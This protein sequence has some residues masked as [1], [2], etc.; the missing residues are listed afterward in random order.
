MPLSDVKGQTCRRRPRG[1]LVEKTD[2]LLGVMAPPAETMDGQPAQTRRLVPLGSAAAWW[3]ISFF[4]MAGGAGLA[5]IL[6]KISVLTQ[7]VPT[8]GPPL[9]E[10]LL[11]LR[12]R[13]MRRFHLEE[14]AGGVPAVVRLREQILLASQTRLPA[15]IVGPP[16]SGKQ[17]VAR[18]IHYAGP[19]REQT[20][21]CLDCARLAPDRI[22]ELLFASSPGTRLASVYL[23]NLADLPLSLQVRLQQKLEVPR[24]R[25]SPLSR[26]F[27]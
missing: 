9:S 20:F 21:G 15:L 19:E 25:L 5:G 11:S 18:A 12:E 4:P 6:G 17:W 26:G 10:R 27:G 13:H 14:L 7:P 23:K 1:I 2:L 16:G 8:V 22:A 3:H 24:R